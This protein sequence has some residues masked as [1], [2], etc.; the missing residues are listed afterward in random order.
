MRARRP[1]L[2]PPRRSLPLRKSANSLHALPAAR[3]GGDP[4]TGHPANPWDTPSG[5]VAARL[6]VLLLLGALTGSRRSKERPGDPRTDR[7]ASPWATN[8]PR[9]GC[10]RPAPRVSSPTATSLDPHVAP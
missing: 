8:A 1:P 3:T 9:P 4:P 6:E 5:T 2:H 10:A 7:V